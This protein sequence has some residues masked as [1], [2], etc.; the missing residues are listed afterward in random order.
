MLLK[1]L[2]I[3]NVNWRC[4]QTLKENVDNVSDICFQ[5]PSYPLV[6]SLPICF[7][8]LRESAEKVGGL[9]FSK[10]GCQL[11]ILPL[12]LKTRGG[13]IW[14]SSCREQITASNTNEVYLSTGVTSLRVSYGLFWHLRSKCWK[15]CGLFSKTLSS[16][17][18]FSYYFLIALLFKHQTVQF[19]ACLLG[20]SSR[21]IVS[22]SPLLYF[23]LPPAP[24]I[25]LLLFYLFSLH[26]LFFL[27][28]Y[29]NMTRISETRKFLRHINRVVMIIFIIDFH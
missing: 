12:V 2:L 15:V 19:N 20:V 3:N 18:A 26:F 8:W 9:F 25:F 23:F 10:D 5:Y 22:F 29:H 11:C 27:L 7:S 16:H 6:F 28:L 14:V 21:F 13:A 17:P 4:W 24:F 1:F